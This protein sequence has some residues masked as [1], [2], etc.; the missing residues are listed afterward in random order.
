MALGATRDCLVE[1]FLLAGNEED[2]LRRI[3]LLRQADSVPE[4]HGDKIRQSFSSNAVLAQSTD[5]FHAINAI[6]EKNGLPAIPRPIKEEQRSDDIP[7]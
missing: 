6:L 5:V 4:K 1:Q 3:A 2:A 7:F